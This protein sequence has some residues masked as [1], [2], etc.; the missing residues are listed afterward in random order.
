MEVLLGGNSKQRDV[1]LKMK[2]VI[3]DSKSNIISMEIIFNDEPNDWKNTSLETYLI[4]NTPS[5]WSDFFNRENITDYI[6]TI[7][8]F[9]RH[10]ASHD[11]ITIY[12][13]ISN[14]FRALY[15]IHPED[16]DIVI[17]GQDPYH[18]GA[19]TGL[20]F[21]V[22]NGNRPNPSLRNIMK[23]LD[24]CGFNTNGHLTHWPEQGILL[25]NTALT[26]RKAS[27]GSHT[28]IWSLFT[29]ELIGYIA[30]RKKLIWLLMGS[31]AQ[32]YAIMFPDDKKHVVI[33][34]THPSP[35]SACR[36]TKTT[37]AFIGSDC[38][39]TI[40]EELLKLG[41]SPIKF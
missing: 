13:N 9:L 11:D 40:N 14:V 32:S 29:E 28:K 36:S 18:D 39:R 8:N 27:P 6:H 26:V 31:H 20:A 15:M 7:S 24:S 3:V 21:D 19:A 33:K 16:I 23:E 10:E 34:T 37:P 5:G 38:F 4:D 30:N 2:N 22:A 17:I 35:L 12:P 25:I 1:L 41:K